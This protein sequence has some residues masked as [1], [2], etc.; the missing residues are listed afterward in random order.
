MSL[1]CRCAHAALLRAAKGTAGYVRRVGQ[2]P[3]PSKRILLRTSQDVRKD[4]R[5]WVFSDAG[6]E[7]DR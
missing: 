3:T 2:E 5:P 6:G 4:M 1:W 7:V